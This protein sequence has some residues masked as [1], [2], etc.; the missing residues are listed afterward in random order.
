MNPDTT[1]QPALE[2]TEKSHSKWYAILSTVFVLGL[3]GTMVKSMTLPYKSFDLTIL[4]NVLFLLALALNI[5][6]MIKKSP[7]WLTLF[8]WVLFPVLFIALIFVGCMLGVGCL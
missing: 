4:S 5:T 1:P 6:A 3:F 8:N 2:P 7:R